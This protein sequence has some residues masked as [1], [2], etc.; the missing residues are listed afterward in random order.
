MDYPITGQDYPTIEELSHSDLGENVLQR[1]RFPNLKKF[2]FMNENAQ[3]NVLNVE[4][5]Q[6]MKSLKIY[7]EVSFTCLLICLFNLLIDLSLPFL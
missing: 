1:C 4:V 3:M 7:K 6:N 2:I 5:L